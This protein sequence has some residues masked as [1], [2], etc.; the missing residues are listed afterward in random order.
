MAEL[1][2]ITI[3][4]LLKRTAAEHPSRSAI[5]YLGRTWTWE[6][7]D[8]VSDDVARGLLAH[9]VYKGCHVGIFAPDRPSFIIFMLAIVKIGAVAV[10]INPMLVCSELEALLASAD[11]EFLGVGSVHKDR[12]LREVVHSLPEMPLLKEVIYLGD[13]LD[14][15][16]DIRKL[17]ADGHEFEKTPEGRGCL[18][19]AAADVKP[20][21]IATILF[22][23]GTTGMPKAVLISHH[24]RV[25]NAR[26]QAEDLRATCEDRFCIAIPMFHCFC[27]S[28]S[29]LAAL[30]VGATICLPVN[31]RTANVMKVL[32][33]GRCT[34]FNAVPTLF[35]ALMARPDFSEYD[36][37][38]LRIGII[39]GAGYTT[40]QFKKIEQSFGFRLLSSLG[41]TEATGGV[42]IAYPED[43]FEVRSTTVGHFMKHA[44]GVILDIKTGEELPPMREGEI[45]ISGY[46]V[47]KGYYKQPELTSKTI[48]EQGRLHTGDMGY[49][50]NEGN[51]HVTGRI[52]ELIIRGGENISPLQIESC[53]LNHDRRIERAKVIGVPDE[54]YGEEICA[55]VILAPG[56]TMSEEEVR[57]IARKNLAA[58]KVPKYVLFFDAFPTNTQGKV[59]ASELKK[60]AL[61]RIKGH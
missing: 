37:S 33:E 23:S 20:S 1:I 49:I 42:T 43:S 55:C 6:E 38:S 32:S 57:E 52:K 26:L 27:L 61:S 47:M 10:L 50:D 17:L 22:T 28:A 4:E 8:R 45:C 3:G 54:H 5:E 16:D 31:N 11:V 30:S 58:Y 34:I 13:T 40:E 51:L 53:L 7:V 24:S 18:E 25:N 59:I 44:R 35:F 29:V 41:M 14:D 9:G 2:D 46:Q 48:D 36:L 60:A 21:D 39:G 56:E 12:D 19:K 15:S